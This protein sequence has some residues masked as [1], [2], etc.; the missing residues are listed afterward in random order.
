[1]KSL[2]LLVCFLAITFALT[3]REYQTSF[4]SWMQ[5]HQKS[6]HH[7]DFRT[8]YAIFKANLDKINA[9]NAKGKSYTLAMNKFGDLTNQEFNMLYKGVSLNVAKPLTHQ[10]KALVS[11]K[12][13]ASYDW[14]TQGAVT[15]VKD[16]GQCGSCWSF[17]TTGSVEGCH[18]LATKKLVSLSEQNLVDC[19][20]RE[21]N[22]GCDGGLMTQAM[23]YIIKNNGIDTEAS[24]PYTAADGTCHFSPS[25]VGS[26][27][28]SYV[29][30]NAGDEGDLLNKVALGPVSVAI[31]ASQDSFQFY[32][33][34]VYDEPNCST[35]ALDHCVLAVGWGTDSGSGKDYWI[36]KNSWSA[37]WGL[38][39]YIWMSRNNGNQC[40]I[41]TAATLPQC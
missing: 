41:A 13:P 19:S 35:S 17:S 7:I 8:R 22:D 2:I 24:Y 38:E 20:G 6:Y 11:P 30:I 23:D 16:Q 29:N 28:K 33:S 1:M 39:G 5:K 27:L 32:S 26:T 9:H 25:N 34:G 18:F 12:V 37:S 31:D 15:G 14:R 3:E 10:P 36:V 4:T 21:G 40:G